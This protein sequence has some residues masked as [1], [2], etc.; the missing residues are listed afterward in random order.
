MEQAPPGAEK[1]EFTLNHLTIDGATVYKPEDLAPLY[2][3]LIGRKI[4]LT[5][6]YDLA[7][8]LT[9]KYRND[10]Y[11]LSQIIVPPQTIDGGT[12]KLQAVEGYI[13]QVT[14]KSERTRDTEYFTAYGA[15][16][17]AAKPL[18]EKTLE[19]YMLLINDIPGVTAKSVLSPSRSNAGAS[20]LTIAVEHKNVDASVQADNRGSRFMGPGQAN[21]SARLNDVLGYG[22]G[23]TVQ[24][25]NSL[26]TMKYGSA[27]M[28]L[29]L[30]HNGTALNLSGAV[31]ATTPGYTLAIFDIKGLSHAYSIGLTHA[32][33]RSRSQNFS[34]T[35]KLDYLDSS[36]SDNLGGPPIVDKLRVLRAGGFYQASDRFAGANTVSAEISKGI[37]NLGAS[38]KGDPNMSRA[39]GDPQFFKATAEI[40]RTQALTEKLDGYLAVTGQYSASPLL[41]SEEFGVGG[42]NY[43]SAYDN[44]EIT[45]KNGIAA[46]LELR[47]SNPIW[48]RLQQIQ[49][50]VFYDIGKI[51]AP[52]AAAASDKINSLASTGLGLRAVFDDTF[53]GAAEW[54]QPLTRNT[55]SRNDKASRVFGSIAAKF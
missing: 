52:Q 2:K 48:S 45:G 41:A 28:S 24:G 14:I 50:Y 21:A 30:G 55:S 13:D 31:T 19:R 53:S 44:S 42:A 12:L 8:K 26:G 54:A 37:G 40:T 16:I 4:A 35:L 1:I 27:A 22:E 25:A 47:A 29:P 20:E 10:G 43:G 49:P 17:R 7:N 51:W 5:A 39:D 6:V 32:F 23:L 9:A 46:R 3:E 15:A 38:S 36:R 34:A 18:N 11:I 33:A